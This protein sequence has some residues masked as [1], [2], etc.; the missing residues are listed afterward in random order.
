[1]KKLDISAER[2]VFEGDCAV[3][4]KFDINKLGDDEILV[5]A[6]NS[7]ISIGTETTLLLKSRWEIQEGSSVDKP[8]HEE[9][10]FDDYGKGEK[11]NMENNRK[12]PGYALAGDKVISLQS[13]SNYA[14]CSPKPWH[15]LPERFLSTCCQAMWTL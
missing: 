2:I 9:W 10:G 1:M 11:W 3:I 4:E 7:L 8:S 13:H 5:K 6:R 12:C 15:T 14:I